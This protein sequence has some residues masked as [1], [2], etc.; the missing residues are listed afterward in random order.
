MLGRQLGYE[1]KI[2]WRTPAA[3][4]FAFVFPI[5]FLVVFATLFK[6]STAHVGNVRVSWNDYYI[7]SLITFGVMISPT[8]MSALPPPSAD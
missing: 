1:Q 4:F 8:F 7:P 6:G 5:I 3:A 2:F